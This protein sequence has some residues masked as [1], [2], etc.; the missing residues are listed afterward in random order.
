MDEKTA[1]EKAE[2]LPSLL[3]P[4]MTRTREIFPGGKT[5]TPTACGFRRSCCSRRAWKPPKS[6][7]A[8]FCKNCPPCRRLPNAARTNC[9]SCGKGWDIIPAR[10]T[11]TRRLKLWRK[12]MQQKNIIQIISF[13]T[14]LMMINTEDFSLLFQNFRQLLIYHKFFYL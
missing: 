10:K 4:G 2:A 9:S 3:C 14:F 11:C 13:L 7:T 1:R 8:D 12:K 6:I 5:Q